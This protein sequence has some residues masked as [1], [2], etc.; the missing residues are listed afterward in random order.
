MNQEMTKKKN[1]VIKRIM[2]VNDSIIQFF[3][4]K[5]IKNLKKK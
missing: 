5:K 4:Q 1:E 2:Y 3:N